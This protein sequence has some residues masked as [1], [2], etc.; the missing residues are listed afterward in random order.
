MS[1]CLR[2][3]SPSKCASKSESPAQTS[4][5]SKSIMFTNPLGKLSPL[6]GET[7]DDNLPADERIDQ[8]AKAGSTCNEDLITI[9]ITAEDEA[10]GTT[11]PFKQSAVTPSKQAT[12]SNSS[13]VKVV[14][15]K[16][17]GT[18][19][20]PA[21]QMNL[22]GAAM[23]A[24]IAAGGGP[25]TK[26][27]SVKP[28]PGRPGAFTIIMAAPKAVAK[29]S[30]ATAPSVAP[31]PVASIPTHTKSVLQTEGASKYNLEDKHLEPAVFEDK[32]AAQEV[33][34]AQAVPEVRA[35][36]QP[37]GA[38][39]ESQV[40]PTLAETVSQEVSAGVVAEVA[41]S[42]GGAVIPNLSNGCDN[43][44]ASNEDLTSSAP[45]TITADTINSSRPPIEII[46][47]ESTVDALL[48]EKVPVVPDD[49]GRALMDAHKSAAPP[50]DSGT[51]V[52][53]LAGSAVQGMT[54]TSAAGSTKET[55]VAVATDDLFTIKASSG[56]NTKHLLAST[57]M[58]HPV[59]PA[60]SATMPHP[61]APATSATM[62]HPVA[63]A[64]SA[65]MPHPVAPATSATMPHPVAPATSATMPHPVAP[66][67]SATMPHPVAPAT[68][69]TMPHDGNGN[70]VGWADSAAAA[71][72]GC[73]NV[74]GVASAAA[75]AAAD[76][77]GLP[78]PPDARTQAVAQDLKVIQVVSKALSGMPLPQ[79][80]DY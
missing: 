63:P 52:P 70:D 18:I 56:V 69:A 68:S 5:V 71:A 39:V 48:A 78:C 54:S 40:Q 22:V 25:T 14:E 55:D 50:T 59:A 75:A 9:H 62:P 80:D 49:V 31:S 6:A 15:R 47:T 12:A 73:N 21:W 51:E 34:P 23:P 42:Q 4:N 64:T 19:Q 38:G 2:I 16:L 41:E 60:T 20:G 77:L 30:A 8:S 11:S 53:L 74:G 10:A 13:P 33:G 67:T 28:M 45:T 76:V 17:T 26:C 66:A 35:Q 29:S 1:S 7:D 61:V 37:A 43:G 36:D 44:H 32:L 79:G 58:P 65:T 3:L 72:N 46:A 27:L 57:T 24:L